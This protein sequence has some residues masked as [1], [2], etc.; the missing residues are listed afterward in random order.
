MNIY[1]ATKESV[2]GILVIKLGPLG[3]EPT[4]RCCVFCRELVP[5]ISKHER[6]NERT[7]VAFIPGPLN[8]VARQIQSDC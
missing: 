1:N 3:T 2:L 5:P 6:T 7:S 8:Y 4:F